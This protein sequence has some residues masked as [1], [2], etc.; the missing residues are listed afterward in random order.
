MPLTDGTL[1][2]DCLPV[3][4]KAKRRGTQRHSLG[5]LP[6]RLFFQRLRNRLWRSLVFARYLSP[7][8]ATGLGERGARHVSL[9]QSRHRIPLGCSPRDR[10]SRS[11]L[12]LAWG[13][14]QFPRLSLS[15]SARAIRLRQF[16]QLKRNDS[17]QRDAHPQWARVQFIKHFVERF[18]NQKNIEHTSKLG[19]VSWQKFGGLSSFSVGAQEFSGNT[20]H[21]Q[22]SPWL[23]T[24]YV[25]WMAGGKP[26]QARVSRVTERT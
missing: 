23:Q 22:L 1:Q 6:P 10:H 24:R 5:H 11:G 2:L 25:R 14:R 9:R 15:F 18:I 16:L 26:D 13:W 4:A 19:A 12:E 7:R 8:F 17:H 3:P 20:P 21:P